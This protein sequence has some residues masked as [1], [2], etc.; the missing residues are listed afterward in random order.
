MVSES[1]ELSATNRSNG[2]THS[3]FRAA[4]FCGAVIAVGA[5]PTESLG[6]HSFASEF[7]VDQPFRIAGA[8][9]EIQWTNPHGWLHVD[10]EEDGELVTYDFELPSPNTL[11][12]QGWRRNDLQPGDRIIV[13]GHRARTRPHV[14]RANGISRENGNAVFGG[15]V[16]D[17]DE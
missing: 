16:E 2:M 6:H 5:V 15:G 11:M 17:L 10:V 7:D 4:L 8:V 12:R 3:G 9:K 1:E 13:S 14:G